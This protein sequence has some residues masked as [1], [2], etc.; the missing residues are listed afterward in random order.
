MRGT[1][2]FTVV[3]LLAGMT[4]VGYL[5]TATN[6]VPGGKLGSGT[7]TISGYDVSSVDYT[8]DT[9]PTNLASVAFALDTAPATG[10]IVKI[11]L[12]A[13]GSTWF[14]CTISGTPATNASCPVAGTTLA[15]ADQLTVVVG[16]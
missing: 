1:K 15:S 7:G 10:A 3:C 11:K 16:D 8:L 14:N 2:R 4:L 13:A 5:F 12:V 6:T 9:T